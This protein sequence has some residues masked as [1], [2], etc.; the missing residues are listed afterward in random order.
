MI[1]G[2]GARLEVIETLDGVI[3]ISLNRDSVLGERSS[4]GSP[5]ELEKNLRAKYSVLSKTK[6]KNS[7]RKK[8]KTNNTTNRL[9][10]RSDW[11]FTHCSVLKNIKLI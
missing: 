1:C 9:K 4:K 8:D 2:G 6:K 5:D 7:P 3:R 10:R 11:R